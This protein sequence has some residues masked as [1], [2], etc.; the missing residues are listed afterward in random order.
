MKNFKLIININ[1]LDLQKIEIYLNNLFP[2]TSELLFE[3]K[4]ENIIIKPYN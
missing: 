1:I 3:R 4:N 2:Y